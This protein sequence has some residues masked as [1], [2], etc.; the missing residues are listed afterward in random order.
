MGG[1]VIS[2]LETSDSTTRGLGERTFI[3]NI[4]KIFP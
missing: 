3:S 4:L 2:G 1:N